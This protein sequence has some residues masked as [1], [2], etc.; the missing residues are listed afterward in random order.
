[1]GWRGGWG[2][3]WEWLVA[4]AGVPVLKAVCRRS[5]DL[6]RRENRPRSAP[7]SLAGGRAGRRL[8]AGPGREGGN[9]LG[10]GWD[11]EWD[12]W[13]QLDLTFFSFFVFFVRVCL[14]SFVWE[15]VW[16]GRGGGRACARERG[17]CCPGVG[18]IFVFFI[19]S[20]LSPSLSPSTPATPPPLLTTIPTHARTS[21]P[22]SPSSLQYPPCRSD[23][24]ARAADASLREAAPA[25]ALTCSRSCKAW[26]PS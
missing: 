24:N 5:P 6:A 2:W 9:F 23:R 3:E 16:A 4:A 10:Q 1:M 11:G 25:T 14:F 12:W 18:L 15:W 8:R 19:F 17:V 22:P 7:P 20:H 13:A 26:T 21:T